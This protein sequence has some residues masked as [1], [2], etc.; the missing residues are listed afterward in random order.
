MSDKVDNKLITF[1]REWVIDGNGTRSAIC[2]GYSKNG[3]S[4]TANR[5]LKKDKVKQLVAK[6][7]SESAERCE[8]KADDVLR[9]LNDIANADL[10]DWIEVRDGTVRLREPHE[11]PPRAREALKRIKVKKTY[12]K[13][14][15]IT[16]ED[17]DVE[18]YDKVKCK[19]LVGK[20]IGMFTQKTE[21]ELTDGRSNADF[22]AMFESMSTD[23]KLKWLKERKKKNQKN[24]QIIEG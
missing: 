22:K 23:D 24:N 6:F 17:I 13:D 2:A 12:G 15:E 18:L 19:E 14:G 16:S 1:A 8:I 4:A 7:R 3:A 5:L 9:D 21:V 11:R 20:Q 10:E